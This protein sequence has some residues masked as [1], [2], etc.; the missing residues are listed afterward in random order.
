MKMYKGYPEVHVY[1]WGKH[2]KLCKIA[3]GVYV[4]QKNL[5]TGKSL[6]VFKT[7]FEAKEKHFYEYFKNNGLES[8]LTKFPINTNRELWDKIKS[9]KPELFL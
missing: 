3:E 8:T 7:E 5:L 1:R 4:E 9:E 2:K 6:K